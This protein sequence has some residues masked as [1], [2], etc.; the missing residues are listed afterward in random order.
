[1]NGIEKYRHLFGHSDSLE[2]EA[3]WMVG[4]SNVVDWLTW[5]TGQLIGITRTAY[6]KMIV[7]WCDEAELG[8]LSSA[9]KKLV[10]RKRLAKLV[11]SSEASERFS[12][13]RDTI[14]APREAPAESDTSWRTIS[15]KLCRSLASDRYIAT[16]YARF[17]EFAQGGSYRSHGKGNH[18]V[19]SVDIPHADG[20]PELQ[21]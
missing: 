16:L 9:A 12:R 11:E 21:R 10:I 3:P 15:T 14:A 5:S 20:Q 8:N 17:F 1:L 4:V 18:F 7:D 19:T 6:W 2:D 13:P